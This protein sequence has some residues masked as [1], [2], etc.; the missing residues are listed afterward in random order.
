MEALPMLVLGPVFKM[1]RFSSLT[2]EPQ[3][4]VPGRVCRV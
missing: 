2:D 3:N 4:S 1:G